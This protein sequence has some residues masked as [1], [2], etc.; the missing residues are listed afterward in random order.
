MTEYK[1][2]EIMKQIYYFAGEFSVMKDISN[3]LLEK[4][5]NRKNLNSETESLAITLDNSM[6]KF[7]DEYLLFVKYTEKP[8]SLPQ[9]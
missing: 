1:F 7:Y 9:P 8:L 6:Q 2:D 3:I 5:E 4:I